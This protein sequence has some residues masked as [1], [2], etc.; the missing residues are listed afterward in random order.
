MPASP[1]YTTAFSA[2]LKG[3]KIDIDLVR[4]NRASAQHAAG[5]VTGRAWPALA[6]QGWEVIEV[7]VVPLWYLQ[8]LLATSPAPVQPAAPPKSKAD[9]P[10]RSQP[11]RM[12]V[13]QY[14]KFLRCGDAS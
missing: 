2:V 1:E 13:A 5:S 9:Q 7:A 3:A 8:Q 6:G 10:R 14:H 12:T 11:E 4:R